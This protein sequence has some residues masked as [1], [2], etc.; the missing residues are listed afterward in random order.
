MNPKLIFYE[1]AGEPN[2][3]VLHIPVHY[4]GTYHQ[5]DE[6]DVKKRLEVLKR[7]QHRIKNE[8]ASAENRINNDAIK[9][10]GQVDLE[11]AIKN[12]EHGKR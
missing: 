6:H 2:T 1:K 9:A 8:I 5:E 7:A 3:V 12:E 10:S 11:T 4:P